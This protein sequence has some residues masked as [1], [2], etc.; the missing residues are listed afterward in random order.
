MISGTIIPETTGSYPF[1]S[2]SQRLRGTEVATVSAVGAEVPAFQATINVP[3]ALLLSTEDQTVG[4]LGDTIVLS[5]QV[6]TVLSWERGTDSVFLVLDGS[7]NNG[8]STQALTCR[9]PSA[10]GAATIPV[11]IVNMLHAGNL[12]LYSAAY[13]TVQAGDYTV[14]VRAAGPVVNSDRTEVMSAIVE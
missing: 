2:L 6:D 11:S 12:S 9:F 13:E 10:A 5:R 4:A 3:L 1:G 7:L 14:S 8:E